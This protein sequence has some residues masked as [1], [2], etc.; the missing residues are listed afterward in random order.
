M[1]RR[2]FLVKAGMT[3]AGLASVTWMLG[4][5]AR[6]RA[7]SGGITGTPGADAPPW[8]TFE[9]TAKIEV[10]KPVGVT[11]IWMPAALS[12]ETP[13]Q[14]TLANTFAAG[15]GGKAELVKGKSD[16]LGII[17]AEFPDGVKPTFTVSSRVST[18]NV[19]I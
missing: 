5:P 6:V 11:R 12:T 7:E 18:R 13:Y 8:R 1:K 4:G 17:A 2:E 3:S 14:Q 16:A 9:L 15:E 19:A 10:L